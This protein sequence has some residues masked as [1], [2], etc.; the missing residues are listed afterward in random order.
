MYIENDKDHDALEPAIW[1]LRTTVIYK[2][3]HEI[4][5]GG[6]YSWPIT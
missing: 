3:Y 5:P 2:R 4:L 1:I 6:C